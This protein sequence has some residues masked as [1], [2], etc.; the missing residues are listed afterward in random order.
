MQNFEQ[1][2]TDRKNIRLT[3][4]PTRITVK[5]PLNFTQAEVEQAKK[6]ALNVAEK[7][8]SVTQSWRGELHTSSVRLHTDGKGKNRRYQTIKFE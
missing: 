8:G 1:V 5:T 7:M 2:S 3:V 4:T 6:L